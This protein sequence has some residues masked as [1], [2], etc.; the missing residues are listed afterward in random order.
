M[1]IKFASAAATLALALAAGTAAAAE[2]TYVPPPKPSTLT[3]TDVQADLRAWRESGM[4]ELSRTQD[5]PDINN[6]EYLRRQAEYLRL[7]GGAPQA[8]TPAAPSR[9]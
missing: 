4:A 7:R 9:G 6:A 8:S 5:T 3:R 1:T 2:E